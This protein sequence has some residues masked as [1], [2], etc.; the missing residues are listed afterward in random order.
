[1]LHIVKGLNKGIKLSYTLSFTFVGDLEH[2]E[3]LRVAGAFAI[4]IQHMSDFQ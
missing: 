3:C 1:M 2:Y 4:N